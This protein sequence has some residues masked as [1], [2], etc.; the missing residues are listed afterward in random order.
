MPPRQARM[1]SSPVASFFGNPFALDGVPKVSEPAAPMGMLGR[2]I[3]L[4]TGIPLCN[5]GDRQQ[6]AHSYFSELC[7]VPGEL[8]QPLP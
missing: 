5:R 1:S 4:G 3:D 8:P 6:A 2:R 7:G